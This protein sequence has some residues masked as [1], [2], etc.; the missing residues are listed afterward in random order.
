MSIVKPDL[1]SESTLTRNRNGYSVVRVY[2]VTGLDPASALDPKY[3][4]ILTVG[5]PQ[6]GEYHPTVPG[7]RVEE[8]LAVPDSATVVHVHVHYATPGSGNRPPQ[9]GDAP[10]LSVSAITTQE[11]RSYGVDATGNVFALEATDPSTNVKQPVS[12]RLAVP[13]LSIRLLRR[14]DQ[15]PV[16]AAKAYV[17]TV[18]SNKFRNFDVGTLLCAAINAE[19]DDAGKTY[20]V[21]YDFQYAPTSWD[22]LAYFIDPRTGRP[23][24]DSSGNVLAP[25][26]LSVLPSMDFTGLN[27]P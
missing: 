20:L 11:E 18:N 6:Y 27:L 24:L 2:S 23:K 17:G 5:V 16:P 8:V 19:T 10:R 12:V 21:T 22:T 9:L 13:Q 1:I 7:L 26:V 4:A 3:Q 15:D 14:E 25:T